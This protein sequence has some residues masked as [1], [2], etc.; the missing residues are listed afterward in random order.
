MDPLSPSYNSPADA[1]TILV[2][3]SEPGQR[4]TQPSLVAYRAALHDL[5]VCA[6]I[7]TAEELALAEDA[8]LHLPPRE[9]GPTM[10][11]LG[12]LISDP[13]LGCGV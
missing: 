5:C 4:W 3:S 11:Q 9:L 7:D 10:C 13:S 6:R 1:R 12:H 2:P 8:A